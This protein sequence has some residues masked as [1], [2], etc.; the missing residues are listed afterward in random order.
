MVIGSGPGGM[1]AARVAA[2]R[3]HQ[4]SIYEKE[5][6]LGDGQLK[7][8]A[9]PPYKEKMKWVRDY[10]VTQVEESKVE[11]HLGTEVNA[12]MV[13]KVMPDVL[14]IATGAKPLIPST[15]G[16][17]NKNV[18]TTHDVLAG[19]V[20]IEGQ[21]VAVLGQYST[22]AE[23][24]EFLAER[25]NKVTIVARSPIHDLGRGA[26]GST[27]FDLVA[28]LNKN[29]NITILNGCDVREIRE[30]GIAVV[31]RNWKESFLEVDKVV[32]SRGVTPVSELTEQLEGEVAEVYIVGDAAEPRNIA[33]AIYEGSVVARSI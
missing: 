3:G 10:L 21:K 28:R 5:A 16:V 9:V 19:K 31:D 32:L 4:V 14:I 26:Y 1:E 23:T 20:K 7:L 30:N 27:R 24:A 33:A 6:S 18:V 11:V 13:R 15:P 12:D 29:K 25:G 8:A 17:D 2:L 22:G